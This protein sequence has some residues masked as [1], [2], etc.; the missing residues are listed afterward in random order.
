[1]KSTVIPD[2]YMPPSPDDSGN[3]SSYRA[4][5]LLSIHVDLPHPQLLSTTLRLPSTPL[6][7]AWKSWEEQV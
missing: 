7:P 3:A 2:M 4:E 5:A 1:M 6:Q